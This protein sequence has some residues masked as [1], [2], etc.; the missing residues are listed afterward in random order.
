MTLPIILPVVLG[1]VVLLVG[2]LMVIYDPFRVG[3]HLAQLSFTI[4]LSSVLS[5]ALWI[6]GN[7]I[8]VSFY[9]TNDPAWDINVIIGMSI[10]PPV[11]R[12]TIGIVLL[13]A[14]T[15][16]RWD[17]SL[18]ILGAL[19]GAVVGRFALSEA[20]PAEY[21]GIGI[22]GSARVMWT[23]IGAAIGGHAFATAIALRDILQR[24]EP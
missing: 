22:S 11:V 8:V 6:T 20:F 12:W 14:E 13:E 24:R 16:R 1:L 4:F 9:A 15:D 10:G 2:G 3:A 23:F 18:S 17:L 5:W 19:G 7:I 21:S